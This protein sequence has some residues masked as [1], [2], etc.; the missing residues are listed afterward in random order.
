VTGVS[1]GGSHSFLMPGTTHSQQ[2]AFSYDWSVASFTVS[3]TRASGFYVNLFVWPLVL[4]LALGS[5][6]FVLPAA[7]VERVSL[8]VM[9]LL[10]LVVM[11]LM[12]EATAPKSAEPSVVGRLISFDMLMLTLATVLSTLVISVDKESF[13][14]VRKTPQWLKNVSPLVSPRCLSAD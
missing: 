2:E 14:M 3:V 6:V 11:S 8:G 4:V 5:G 10:A 12:M 9:L 1:A 7:C 13:L